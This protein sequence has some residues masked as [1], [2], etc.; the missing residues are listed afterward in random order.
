MEIFG[1]GGLNVISPRSDSVELL[2]FGEFDRVNVDDL[3][4]A[5]LAALRPGVRFVDLDLTA[6]TFVDAGVLTALVRF[7]QEID[8]RRGRLRLSTNQSI[9]RTL[10]ISG[11]APLFEMIDQAAKYA[12]AQVAV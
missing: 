10:E 8:D 12:D 11:L 9:H 4:T 7:Q 3:E 2:L 6:V 1:T 5:M